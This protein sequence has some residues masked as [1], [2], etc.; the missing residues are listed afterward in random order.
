MKY[1]I[2]DG[3]GNYLC[4]CQGQLVW[5]GDIRQADEYENEDDA[6]DVAE[7]REMRDGQPLGTYKVL[8]WGGAQ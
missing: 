6:Q 2:S 8:P 3:Y 7:A 5:D 1:V 4:L